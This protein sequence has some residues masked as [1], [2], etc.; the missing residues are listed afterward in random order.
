MGVISPLT[1]MSNGVAGNLKGTLG[2][3]TQTSVPRGRSIC[4][5]C[6]YARSPL[7]VQITAW[8]PSPE[9]EALTA[10]TISTSEKSKNSAAP[11]ERQSCF[12]FS[13][14]QNVSL[15]PVWQ[16]NP[17]EGDRDILID[18]KDLKSFLSS[19]LYAPGHK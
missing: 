12:F 19:D 14:L 11:S 6:S 5:L 9:V 2:I 18:R 7:A 3:P 1:I 15:S 16:G 4:M 10:S 8:A 17:S 13:P